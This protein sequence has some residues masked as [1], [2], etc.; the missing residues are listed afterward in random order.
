MNLQE[1]LEA[2]A[3]KVQKQR[4]LLDAAKAENRDLSEEEVSVFDQLDAE[5]ESLDGHIKAEQAR[6]EREQKVAAR[7]RELEQ[8]VTK[9]FRPAL[10]HVQKPKLN[11]GGFKNL[12]EFLFAIRFGTEL[13]PG[14]YNSRL[15]ELVVN[16]K[17]GGYEVPE[18]FRSQFVP[19]IRSE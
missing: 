3:E 15:R 2:R 10:D 18:A 6:M 9:P 5:I 17:S 16:E 13:A 14:E 4:E 11:D 1:L 12:G 19:S 7:E 8:P